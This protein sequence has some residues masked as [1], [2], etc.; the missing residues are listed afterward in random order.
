VLFGARSATL[1]LTAIHLQN[2]IHKFAEGSH[3]QNPIRKFKTQFINTQ[4]K[5]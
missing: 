2:Q 5:A 3:L 1:T 4:V